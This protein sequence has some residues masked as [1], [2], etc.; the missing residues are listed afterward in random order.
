MDSTHIATA[1][2]CIT[3]IPCSEMVIVFNYYV[4]GRDANGEW[5]YQTIREED[6]Y[7]CKNYLSQDNFQD[8][9]G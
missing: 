8:D 5:T 3:A 1:G 2:H 9:Y 6:V 4:T 7:S